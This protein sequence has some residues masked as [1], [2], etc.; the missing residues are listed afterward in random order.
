MTHEEFKQLF[1]HPEKMV[2]KGK[3]YE[4]I[5]VDYDREEIGLFDSNCIDHVRWV[6]V[7]K[8]SL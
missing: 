5:A 3:E 1:P 8:V 7:Y 2:Y 6:K 4:I